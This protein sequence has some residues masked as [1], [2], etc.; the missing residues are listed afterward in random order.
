MEGL[1]SHNLLDRSVPAVHTQVEVKHLFPHRNQ[2]TQMAL[3]PGVFL[4]DL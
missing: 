1:S 2:V 3:L 4:R